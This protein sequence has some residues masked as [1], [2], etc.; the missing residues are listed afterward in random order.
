MASFNSYSAP[1]IQDVCFRLA[2]KKG[3]WQNT[4]IKRVCTSSRQTR[5]KLSIANE[6]GTGGSRLP[7][8]PGKA[9]LLLLGHQEDDG[10]ASAP[11]RPP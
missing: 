9:A 7:F 3:P 8:P 5:N 6:R 2:F 4:F 1:V 11:R 10:A